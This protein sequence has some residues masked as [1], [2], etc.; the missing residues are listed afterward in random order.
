MEKSSQ[1]NTTTKEQLIDDI[2]VLYV[3]DE[4]IIRKVTYG[5]LQ[6][7]FKNVVSATNGLE[8]LEEFKKKDYDIVVTDLNMP[9][10]DGIEMITEIKKLSNK[11]HFIVLTAYSES[12]TIL[13]AIGLGIDKYIIKPSG[14]NTLVDIILELRNGITLEKKLYNALQHFDALK[15]FFIVSKTDPKGIITFANEK[16]SKISGYSIDELLGKNHN[17]VRHPD[18]DS[19]AFMELWDRIS[20]KKV[21]SGK[22]K[23]RKKD[24][25]FYIVNATIFPIL[26]DC[27]DIVEYMAIREDITE[28]EELRIKTKLEEEKIKEQE[29]QKRVLEEVSKTKDSFL[30]IFTHELKTPLNAIINF[31]EYAIKKLKKSDF[32]GKDKILSLLSSVNRNG[33]YM[34]NIVTNLLEIAKLKAGKISIKKETINL[35]HIIS[36]IIEDF[37]SIALEKG[38]ETRFENGLKES[39]ISD[40]L[41]VKQIISNI[42][43]NSLKYGDKIINIKT[44]RDENG[45][46]FVLIEDDGSGIKNKDKVFELYAQDGSDLKKDIT[47]SGVGLYFVKLLSAE[48]NLGLKLLD[49][50]SLGG[51]SFLIKFL[52]KEDT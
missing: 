10:L 7:K 27:G 13:S 3:E 12:D 17:I 32:E 31:S 15:E 24:G 26:D 38:I 4:D 21:W 1:E 9:E 40:E 35:S 47:G 22:I 50:K 23:N 8:G 46:A 11:V 37:S 43:S 41:K 14:I 51:A 30:V 25:G 45:I 20:S 5:K 18:M 19:S 49:S 42:Y 36:D 34:L 44:G 33:A 39:V 48:L 28:L 16:F 2:S 52:S 29:A 6:R